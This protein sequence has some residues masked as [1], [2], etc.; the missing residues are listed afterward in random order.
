[1]RGMR[2]LL[3]FAATVIGSL[4]LAG[5]AH[6][7]GPLA[8]GGLAGEKAGTVQAPAGSDTLNFFYT[9]IDPSQFPTIISEVKVWEPGY[10]PIEGLT[11]QNFTVYENGILQTPIKVEEF[12]SDSGGVS[13]VMVM[14]VSGSMDDEIDDAKAA[15]V[16]FVTLLSDMDQAA[17]IKF[18]KN[19]E[20]VQGFTRDKQ[21]LINAI[22]GL[23]L[24]DGTSVYDGVMLALDLLQPVKGKRAVVVLSDGRDNSSDYS[25]DETVQRAKNANIPIFAIGLGLKKKRGRQE[26]IAIAQGSGGIF[27]DSPTSRELE[28]IY[29]RIA[30]I[31]SSYYYRI[32]YTSSNCSE[33]GSVR[34]V[35]ITATY[36]GRTGTGERQYRAPGTASALE[37]QTN[38]TPVPGERFTVRLEVPSNAGDIYQLMELRIQVKY[39]ARYLSIP[40]PVNQ[41]VRPGSLLGSPGQFSFDINHNANSGILEL[42]IRRN[43][44]AGPINGR[45]V[46][47]EITFANSLDTPDQTE[48]PIELTLLNANNPN[49]CPVV[50]QVQGLNLRSDGMLVWPG[51]TNH[52][53]TVELTDVLQLGI[54]WAISGPPRPGSEDQL[55]WEPHVARRFSLLPATYADADGNGIITERDLIPIGLNW[56]KTRDQAS[57]PKAA[58]KI[59][60]L[61]PGSLSLQTERLP[62]A[63]RYRFSLQYHGQ[64]PVI[65]LTFRL[66]Y[67][68][69]Q[70]NR[71][72][73]R[74]AS[75]WGTGALRFEKQEPEN[76]LVAF[77]IMLPPE[78]GGIVRQKLAEW[79][80][81]TNQRTYP[82]I[83]QIKEVALVLADG[84]IY[85]AA[86]EEIFTET[87]LETPDTET[88][89]VYPAFPN[90]FNP[91]T[92]MRYYL[93]QKSRVAVMIY[94]E[95]G[96]VVRRFEQQWRRQGF[97]EIHW[98]GRDDSNRM[99]GSGMYFIAVEL[100]TPEGK[101]F[102]HRQKVLLMK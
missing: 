67:V 10:V 17:L 42:R 72:T 47:A 63:G 94:N 59:S 55:A 56:K 89:R 80:A 100:T 37:L 14:D 16:T 73:I 68:P 9:W 39:D 81:E 84:Q 86:E 44:N 22:N 15:A 54:Y 88:F 99:V 26:L 66:H 82:P 93:P 18:D 90:P 48:L 95:L 46:L 40:D 75:G 8:A 3:V 76:G 57:R 69:E 28:E 92:T 29:R 36:N 96:Q 102:L 31:L 78:Q 23:D 30:F 12:K 97:H 49:G 51:D 62:V 13:V 35:Q 87:P 21:V 43:S 83:I 27:Y 25:L 65:G 58:G 11:E 24:G 45:G 33:D 61:P 52:N 7:A 20:L 77:A 41:N 19:A 53:G 32:T 1:M 79:T 70:V 60:M 38:A 91:I 101:R 64:Q 50:L 34:R 6:M 98:D 85:E 4:L 5:Y 74:P 2:A 71:V